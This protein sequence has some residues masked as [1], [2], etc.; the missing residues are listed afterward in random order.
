MAPPDVRGSRGTPPRMYRV[1]APRQ[2]PGGIH[3][4]GTT[5]AAP[6]PPQ[7]VRGG[8]DE[9]TPSKSDWP[10]SASSLTSSE[11]PARPRPHSS[12]RPFP[13][14]S[15]LRA[16]GWLDRAG[17]APAVSVGTEGGVCAARR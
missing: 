10:S 2:A 7:A 5:M 11:P 12:R 14:P 3:V 16:C 6:P 15:R 13:P 9:A 17:M 4:H 8:L 1:S